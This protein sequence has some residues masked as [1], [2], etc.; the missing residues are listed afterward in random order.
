MQR[1]CICDWHLGI[2]TK[3]M[4]LLLWETLIIRPRFAMS[5]NLSMPEAEAYISL[6]SLGSSHYFASTSL[7]SN[8]NAPIWSMSIELHE[9]SLLGRLLLSYGLGAMQIRK[10][11][12]L[13]ICPPWQLQTTS[14]LPLESCA[15]K[16]CP[17]HGLSMMYNDCA[18]RFCPHSKGLHWKGLVS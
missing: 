1:N 12:T 10:S 13:K 11:H 2:V 15:L 6:I 17:P 7:P 5:A 14:L 9:K 3:I 16:F 8:T 18:L 4:G